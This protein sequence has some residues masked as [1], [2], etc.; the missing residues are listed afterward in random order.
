MGDMLVVF[1]LSKAYRVVSGFLNQ[2]T[3]ARRIKYFDSME[4]YSMDIE[5]S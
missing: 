3:F 1:L 2:S 5:A 4:N